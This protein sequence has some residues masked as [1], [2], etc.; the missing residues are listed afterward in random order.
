MYIYKNI[1]HSKKFVD[2]FYLFDKIGNVFTLLKSEIIPSSYG[3]L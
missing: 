3:S 1:Y 2:S